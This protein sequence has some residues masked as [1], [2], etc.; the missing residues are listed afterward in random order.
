[1]AVEKGKVEGLAYFEYF[2]FN[3]FRLPR[4]L[5]LGIPFDCYGKCLPL[6]K[7]ASWRWD[8]IWRAPVAYARYRKCKALT[9]QEIYRQAGTIDDRRTIEMMMAGCCPPELTNEILE[10]GG[11][12]ETYE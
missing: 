3:S 9:E 1:M 2:W 10:V 6:V 11:M 5:S 7:G 12:P 4:K 8:W